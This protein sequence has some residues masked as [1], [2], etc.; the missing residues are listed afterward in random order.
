[1]NGNPEEIRISPNRFSQNPFVE[2]ELTF[3]PQ[4]EADGAA[5]GLALRR[6]QGVGGGMLRLIELT[7]NCNEQD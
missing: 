3:Q 5:N 1:M 7:C 6:L 4:I 2:Q